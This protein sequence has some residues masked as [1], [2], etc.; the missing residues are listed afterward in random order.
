MLCF[1][2]VSFSYSLKGGPE[3]SGAINDVSFEIAA[4]EFT[5]LIGE[6]GAGK[7]TLCRLCNGLLKPGAGKVRAAGMNTRTTKPSALARRVGFLFQ[8]PDRQLCQ[9]TVR[10]EILIG[11]EY[12]LE[13]ASLS[14]PELEA[15]KKRRCDEML[16][17]FGLDGS[18]DP[19]GLSRGERQQCALASVLARQPDLLILD[20]P[21]T[22][23]D[24]REC[25]TMMDI[26]SNLNARGTTIVMISHD[27][28]VVADFARRCLVLNR[29][30]LIG[31]GPVKQVMKN[32]SLLEKA[33]L[34]PSQISS[35]ALRLGSGFEHVFSVDDMVGVAE[36]FSGVIA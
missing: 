32:K 21:T 5:A 22:G 10:D 26:I 35:L 18:R 23:L 29:G 13:G 33:S 31:D 36:K 28:E 34:L 30:R 24:Y 12:V 14:P 1:E 9:N 17:L 8:N 19:F 16:S 6:N 25:M 7:S 11:L 20:E 15:E 4:G 3:D 2:K 27:M